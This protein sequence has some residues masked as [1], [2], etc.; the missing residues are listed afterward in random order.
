MRLSRVSVLL[1]ILCVAGP[2]IAAAQV[3]QYIATGDNPAAL[4]ATVA[5]FRADLGGGNI[6]GPNG[7]YGGVRREIDWEDVPD[8]NASPAA[9]PIH[10]YN[11]TSP[12]G[13]D[14]G[15]ETSTFIRIS[16]DDDTGGDA[17]PDLVRFSDINPSFATQFQAFSGQRIGGVVGTH[18]GF[19]ILMRMPGTTTPAVTRGAGIVLMGDDG[20]TD[21]H[22]VAVVRFYDQNLD[23]F[24]AIVI[25]VSKMA[26]VGITVPDA[27]IALIGVTLG[28]LSL[29]HGPET[30]GV[31][32]IL[33]FDDIIYGEPQLARSFL[34]EG[35]SG[36]FDTDVALANP[37][38]TDQHVELKFLEENGNTTI[39]NK[40]VPQYGRLTVPMKSVAGL[41]AT[42]ASTVITPQEGLPLGVERTMFWG[43]NRYGGH[44]GNAITT[45]STRWYFAEGAQGFFDTFVLVTNQNEAPTTV[46][47]TFLR[48]NEAPFVTAREMTPHSRLTLYAGAFPEL[49]NRAFGVIVDSTRRSA[50]CTSARPRSSSGRA[51][52]SRLARW[53]RGPTGIFRRARPGTTSI[54]SSC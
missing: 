40:I 49:A 33:T 4:Q 1:A 39:V 36:F 20:V 54:P 30:P 52:M 12:R 14:F 43:S 8:A 22:N 44:T 41:E 17:D 45:A 3:T 51:A 48:E 19:S 24:A 23:Y 26:F 47:F 29:D 53:S 35:A 18:E 21:D 13:A 5:A 25:P 15:N 46:T 50:R 37:T 32:D 7:S 38:S 9:F 27:R 28:N 34:P 11:T 2:S 16:Q 6:A 31:T 10:Y 42:S